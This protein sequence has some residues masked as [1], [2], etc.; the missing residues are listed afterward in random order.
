MKK[1]LFAFFLLAS[2]STVPVHAQQDRDE[3]GKGEGRKTGAGERRPG[4]RPGEGRPGQEGRPGFGG[5]GGP[6][7]PMAGQMMK[8]LPIMTA[9]DSDGNGELSA[10]EIENASKAILKLDK[11]GDGIIN[12]EELRPDPASLPPMMARMGEEAQ[13]GQFGG[14]MMIRMFEAS[15]KNKDGKLSGDE[16]PE[17]M[18]ERVSKMD[19]DGDG[20]ISRE[21]MK[22]AT[23]MMEQ[24]GDRPGRGNEDAGGAVKP[25]RPGSN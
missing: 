23:E 16:I 1:H 14:A 15:D 20:A 8:F 18:K 2:L 21:E 13:G 19:Q 6:M 17:R 9:L 10:T 7:G 11:N 25:K 4:F 22:R 12:A 24:R 3:K 5:P